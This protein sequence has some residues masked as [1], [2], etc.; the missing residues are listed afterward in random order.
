MNVESKPLLASKQ[1]SEDFKNRVANYDQSCVIL[2][3]PFLGKFSPVNSS[4]EEYQYNLE[5]LLRDCFKNNLPLVIADD[6]AP[7][8]SNL[9]QSLEPF[10]G[11]AFLLPT[12][13]QSPRP[14]LPFDWEDLRSLL[15]SSQ[16]KKAKVG[17]QNME[18]ASIDKR[19]ILDEHPYA[20]WFI[21]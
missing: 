8:F 7:S 18:F 2:V 1:A 12:R 15:K 19:G 17:G 11:S 21:D 20:D 13:A 16:V 6:G 9:Y 4:I 10:K 14:D 5:V 3:H